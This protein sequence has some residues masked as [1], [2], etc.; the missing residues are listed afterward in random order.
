MRNTIIIPF[1]AEK[2]LD[3][4]LLRLINKGYAVKADWV[5]RRGSLEYYDGK[6]V[7]IE[8]WQEKFVDKKWRETMIAKNCER[9]D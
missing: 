7:V 5:E 9:Y 1:S 2:E 3:A 6:F 8:Y 4:L